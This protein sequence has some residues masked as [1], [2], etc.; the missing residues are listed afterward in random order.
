MCLEIKLFLE[1]PYKEGKEYWE[2]SSYNSYSCKEWDTSLPKAG[3]RPLHER[4]GFA[5]IDESKPGGQWRF[6]DAVSGEVI[7]SPHFGSRT[8][9]LVY[10]PWK[11]CYGYH[12]MQFPSPDKPILFWELC[13]GKGLVTSQI[14][15]GRVD[16]SA[17]IYQRALL[18]YVISS[19]NSRNKAHGLYLIDS[20]GS[21]KL[22][23]GRAIHFSI[24]PD[25]CK[26]A[27]GEIQHEIAISRPR[28]Q[29]IT[30]CKKG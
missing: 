20:R 28:I 17:V 15:Y 23:T 29:A 12:S 1:V 21:A 13:P 14:P 16:S 8:P 19:A 22:F 26:I 3:T 6:H 11:E 18:G 27:F 25:G 30:L 5:R 7:D 10:I 2:N 9:E 4:H 24:S